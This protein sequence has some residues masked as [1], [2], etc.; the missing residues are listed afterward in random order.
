MDAHHPGS[1]DPSATIA[2]DADPIASDDVESSIRR[3]AVYNDY[4]RGGG[5]HHRGQAIL[6]EALCVPD[7]YHDG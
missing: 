3:A 1:R 2:Q 4:L 6:D 7:R 5:S